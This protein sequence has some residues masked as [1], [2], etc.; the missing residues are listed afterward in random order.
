MITIQLIKESTSEY[1]EV[2]VDAVPRVGERV[3]VN[4][5]D[6]EFIGPVTDVRHVFYKTGLGL[7]VQE[8]E[9]TIQDK[10]VKQRS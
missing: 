7:H 9:V 4:V 1:V 2:G 8:I 10:P 6:F 3:S 5:E